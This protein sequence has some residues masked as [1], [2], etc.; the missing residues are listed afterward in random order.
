M[1]SLINVNVFNSS[2]Y[3]KFDC[4]GIKLIL[5]GMEA[6]FGKYEDSRKVGV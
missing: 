2:K 6:I 5:V 4:Q 3:D 1:T